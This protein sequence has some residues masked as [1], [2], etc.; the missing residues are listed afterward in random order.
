MK[1]EVII[2]NDF[3]KNPDAVIRYAKTLS[4]YYPWASHDIGSS[5]PEVMA[6]A[7]WHASFFKKAKD[8]PFKSSRAILSALEQ[9]TGEE[10]DRAHWNKDFPENSSDGTVLN[11]RPDLI[12]PHKSPT[13]DNIVPEG[14]SCR[15]NFAF[16]VK[17]HKN[18]LGE[19]VHNHVRDAWNSVGRDGWSGLIYLNKDAPRDSGLKTFRNKYGDD[20]EWMTE[21][22][23]WQLLDE[24]A[25]IFNRLILVRG[26]MPH[27]GGPGFGN[28]IENGRLF[29][30]LFFKTKV[31]SIESCDIRL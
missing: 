20:F 19:G 22:D 17:Y 1:R 26:W 25:N 2:V 23:R 4:Y 31:Q 28:S 16:H 9:I 13:Y 11:P 5:A 10:I 3:Y 14:T 24:F 15:W 18:A 30:T 27:V 8:C 21:P 12:D 6:K 29:Q 7:E